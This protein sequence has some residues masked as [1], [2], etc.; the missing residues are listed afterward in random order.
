[1]EHRVSA[2]IPASYAKWGTITTRDSGPLVAGRDHTFEVEIVLAK[3]VAAGQSIECWAHFVSDMDYFQVDRPDDRAYFSYDSAAV[4]FE[5]I[6]GNQRVHGPGSFFPYRRFAGGR[7]LSDAP[8]GTRIVCTIRD[9][10]LQTYEET[11]FNLRFAVLNGD[12]LL[13]YIGDAF[14][15]V[16]GDA[17][18][19]L[20][21]VAPTC[22][23]QGEPFDCRIVVRDRWGNK[24]GSVLETLRFTI[25]GAGPAVA[26]RLWRG[27]SGAVT[28][29]D[30]AQRLHLIRNITFADPG[31]YY[32][33]AAV[34]G[35]PEIA[36]T[37]NPIV[38]R[39]S[40]AER[41]YWGDPHQHAYYHDGR[42]TPHANYQYAISTGCLD[43]CAV[44]PH[45]QKTFLPGSLHLPGMPPQKGWEEMIDAANTYNSDAFVTILGS[46]PGSPGGYAGHM[47][48]YFLDMANR[49]ELERLEKRLGGAKAKPGAD[50]YRQYLDELER[51]KGEFL[52]LP[53]AHAGVGMANYNVPPRPDYQTS[54]EILSVH[55]VFDEY[56]KGWLRHGFVMGV[57]GGGDNHMTSTGN[58][59]PGNHYTNTNGLTGAYA[60]ARTRR[61]I[62]DAYKQRRT[63]AVSGNQRIFLEF[64]V[65]DAAMGR[66]V[67]TTDQARKI[68]LTVAG[69]A[70]ILKIELLKNAELF[71]TWRPQLREP[72]Q[73]R[74]VWADDRNSRRT[75]DSETTG[76]IR[77]NAGA[78]K[79]V[80]RLNCYTRTD[81]FQEEDGAVRFRSNGYSGTTRGVILET[82]T[83]AA[84]VAFQVRDILNRTDILN[85]T[86]TIDLDSLPLQITRPL[87]A[88]AAKGLHPSVPQWTLHAD[89]IHPAWPKVAQVEWDDAG[90][91]SAYYFVRIEQIDG[92]IAWSSPVWFGA[93][94]P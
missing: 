55:G 2:H 88:A 74:L 83:E 21:L 45:E 60:P 32:V 52:L 15:Q 73:L 69:T 22:V 71:Q 67:P 36:G 7:L 72:R 79:I 80:H 57:H 6:V 61:G 62:W 31:T 13:G 39:K 16:I 82:A 8:A 48:A 10:S 90:G 40:W 4:N 3:P 84:S 11:L 70:P 63:Y 65:N 51:S 66:V 44:T 30:A 5:G 17:P 91:D 86:V 38:V 50:S 78:L 94:S 25:D 53:H 56:Y 24:S 26:S 18:H 46:E 75:D 28:E 23:E 42:G 92:N 87:P 41:V 29:W 85:E 47:N 37:G 49:P 20:R 14:Y 68:R 93:G 81:S 89:W 9:V 34:Q 64:A 27:G 19:H 59:I 43:F 77:A 33:R 35:A 12:E 76:L 1:M 58:G 54:A